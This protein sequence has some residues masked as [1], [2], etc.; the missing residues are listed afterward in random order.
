VNV[1]DSS[2]WLEYFSGGPNA[3]VFAPAIEST[4]KLLVP[5]VCLYE[6]LKRY[7]L[8]GDKKGGLERV[9]AMRMGKVVDI[10]EG[11]ALQ[12]SE[13]SVK[14]GLA[15]AD[16]MI[17]AVARQHD[18]QFWTQDVDFKGLPGVK[19]VAKEKSR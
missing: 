4:P 5:S 7:L 3:E 14:H 11:L 6:V 16:S 12:A 10:D 8:N 1:V 2:A 17:Y 9:S 19:F 15:M 13:L 18:A